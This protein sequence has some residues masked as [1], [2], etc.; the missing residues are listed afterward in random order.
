MTTERL[1]AIKADRQARGEP[2]A[3]TKRTGMKDG[4]LSPRPFQFGDTLPA[5]GSYCLVSG[6][7]C[8][9]ESDQHRGYSWRQVLGYSDDKEFVCLQTHKDSYACWPTVERLT[10]C[11]FAEISH[12]IHP[13]SQPRQ[14]AGEPAA[15]SIHYVKL[16]SRRKM[17]ATIPSERWGWW[18]DVCPGERMYLRDA[19]VDDLARC[20]RK[21][22]DERGVEDFFCE[23]SETGALVSKEAVDSCK[24]FKVYAAAPQPQQIPEGYA[25]VPIELLNFIVAKEH[26]LPVADRHFLWA[27]LEAAQEVR[28]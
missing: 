1:A 13:S 28:P 7:N 20:I 17:K 14:Q 19:T 27:M 23:L 6:A 24:T 2:V 10:N 21:A 15:V 12:P 11:W 9:I 3:Y 22:G 8:D 25:L 4:R 5:V 26:H 18:I 16:K